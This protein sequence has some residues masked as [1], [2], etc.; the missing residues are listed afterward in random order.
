M[1][2]R[3]MQPAAGFHMKRGEQVEHD[4]VVVAGVERDPVGGA[5][6]RHAAHHVERPI[7]VE[8]RNLDRDHVLDRGETTP[9]RYRQHDPPTAGCR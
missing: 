1:I 3:V 9:E 7:T 6:L 2:R 4:M 8:G 5:G